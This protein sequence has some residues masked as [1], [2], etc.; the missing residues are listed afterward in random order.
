VKAF[1]R[2]SA[3][4]PRRFRLHHV[5]R[6]YRQRPA[7]PRLYHSG[8]YNQTTGINYYA[9]VI[10]HRSAASGGDDIWPTQ[11][12]QAMQSMGWI[13]NQVLEAGE[14][15]HV[16]CVRTESVTHRT[17]PIGMTCSSATAARDSPLG[18]FF[19]DDHTPMDYDGIDWRRLA[20][21]SS[22]PH[23]SQTS[24]TPLPARSV[25]M[26]LIDPSAVG[27]F[28][29]I[30]NPQAKAEPSR[31]CQDDRDPERSM[32]GRRSQSG[33]SEHPKGLETGVRR[34]N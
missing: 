9:G 1:K 21:I 32:G 13:G 26:G 16:G 14:R 8:I 11:K 25:L 22:S 27:S 7:E 17:A 3:D 20:A 31:D 33:L 23:T 24:S 29:V 34:L 6:G 18:R 5:L 30:Q 4:A 10:N 28:Y 15:A 12:L 19:D 2:F